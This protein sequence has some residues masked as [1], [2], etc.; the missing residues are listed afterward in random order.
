MGFKVGF[1][2]EC[3]QS[4]NRSKEENKSNETWQVESDA[5][6][7]CQS[8]A[9]IAAKRQEQ[10]RDARYQATQTDYKAHRRKPK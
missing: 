7:A 1:I 10:R 8:R 5:R 3:E 6:K 4:I 9:G 2:T